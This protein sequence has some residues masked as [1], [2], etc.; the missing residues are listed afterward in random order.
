VLRVHGQELRAGGL[1]ERHDK[2]AA[3][4]EALLVGE[5]EVDS[6]AERRD[7]RT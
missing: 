2:L 5:R 1:G 6:L 7:G 4:H 3:D